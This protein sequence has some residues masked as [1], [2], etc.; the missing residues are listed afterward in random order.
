MRLSD[1]VWLITAIAEE[2]T[3]GKW[4]CVKYDENHNMWY[5]NHAKSL[6]VANLPATLYNSQDEAENAQP[7]GFGYRVYDA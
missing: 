5:W 1:A 2:Q 4:Y 3:K 7:D 6:W